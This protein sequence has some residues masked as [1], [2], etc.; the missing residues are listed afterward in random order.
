[1]GMEFFYADGWTGEIDRQASINEEAKSRFS[2]FFER[3][4]KR[5]INGSTTVGIKKMKQAPDHKFHLTYN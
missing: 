2:Q 1:M 3:A 4:Q 5:P